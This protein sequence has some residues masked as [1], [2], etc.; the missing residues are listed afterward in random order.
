MAR[1]LKSFWL[2]ITI[3]ILIAFSILITINIINI[4]NE[5]IQ[6]TRIMRSNPWIAWQLEKE[7]YRFI[8]S[9]RYFSLTEDENYRDNVIL[10]YEILLSRLPLVLHGSEAEMLRQIPGTTNFI[11]TMRNDLISLENNLTA[12]SASDREQIIEIDNLLN[13]YRESVSALSNRALLGP[14]ITSMREK[15]LQTQARSAWLVLALSIASAGLVLI[16]MLALA[17]SHRSSKNEARLR[18]SAKLLGEMNERM[19]RRL[20][21]IM[22]SAPGCLYAIEPG[23]SEVDASYVSPSITAITGFPVWKI[24]SSCFFRSRILPEDSRRV[25]A[26][27]EQLSRKEQSSI[28]FRFRRADGEVIWLSESARLVRDD[29]GRPSEI[30]GLIQDVTARR[31]ADALLQQN[32]KLMTLGEMATGLAHELNQPLNVIRMAAQN[33]LGRLESEC[34]FRDELRDFLSAKLRRIDLQIER[35]AKLADHMRIFGRADAEDLEDFDTA[36][37]IGEALGL[38]RP[39]LRLADIHLAATPSPNRLGVLGSRQQLEQVIINL[40]LN[41]RD[42]ILERRDSE[43]PGIPAWIRVEAGR[44]PGGGQAL[45]TVTDSGGGVPAAVITRLFQ[46]FVSTKPPGKGTGLGL[47]LSFGIVSDMGGTIRVDNVEQGACFTLE[48]PLSEAIA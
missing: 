42:A 15:L 24:R 48:L 34:G 21:F 38:L 28:E 41:A 33:A 12:L 29:A 18:H 27:Y 4:N 30:I 25:L 17:A 23:A 20:Q 37:V 9:I 46:P 2:S 6:Y 19:R 14:E 26:E 22:N 45:I 44:S 1:N 7:F 32:A 8:K 39:Q 40:V 5:R 10:R 11:E 3:S 43:G 35:A 47:S 36:E 13:T 16:L 31:Q